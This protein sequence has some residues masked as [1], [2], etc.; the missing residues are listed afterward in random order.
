MNTDKTTIDIRNESENEAY[1]RLRNNGAGHF[2]SFVNGKNWQKEKDKAIIEKA[3]EIAVTCRFW[4]DNEANYPKD[5]A[6]YNLAQKCKEFITQ[7]EKE[8]E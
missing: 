3:F 2:G 1:H 8:T 6:G 7:L 5:T 4:F